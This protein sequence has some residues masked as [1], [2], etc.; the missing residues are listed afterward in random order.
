MKN[1]TI[2]KQGARMLSSLENVFALRVN[3]SKLWHIYE[4]SK[5]KLHNNNIV[6][7]G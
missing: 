3:Q 5:K 7:C 1:A 6:F 4:K 2:S